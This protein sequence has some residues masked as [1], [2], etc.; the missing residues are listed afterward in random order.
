MGLAAQKMAKTDA[1]GTIARAAL[2]LA[3]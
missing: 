2:E 3:S 1:A